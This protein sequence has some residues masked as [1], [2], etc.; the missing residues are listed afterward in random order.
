MST[1]R[2][3]GLCPL[4]GP[5]RRSAPAPN[6]P[7]AARCRPPP[8]S[9]R[10]PPPPAPDQPGPSP[11]QPL[12]TGPR[13]F[14]SNTY[15][16]SRCRLRH[17]V[18]ART[19]AVLLLSFLLL[20]TCWPGCPAGC[21]AGQTDLLAG[22]PAGRTDLL[23]GC[24]AGRADWRLL[25]RGTMCRCS[26]GRLPRSGLNGDVGTRPPTPPYGTLITPSAAMHNAASVIYTHRYC[27]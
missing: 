15:P 21:L 19:S 16:A 7:T 24:P 3:G 8:G 22:C 6:R 25:R 17:N 27:H 9:S 1:S 14:D 12:H 11:D 26:R 13:L 4:A 2:S 18:A 5:L 23:A 10:T 20:Q